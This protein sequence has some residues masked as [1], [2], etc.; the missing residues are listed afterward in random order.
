MADAIIRAA[1]VGG[2]AAM[3]SYYTLK[4]VRLWG[5][6][7]HETLKICKEIVF[8]PPSS[9]VVKNAQIVLR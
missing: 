7:T 6:F 1:A 5:Y 4:A 3:W 2:V 9:I 8:L